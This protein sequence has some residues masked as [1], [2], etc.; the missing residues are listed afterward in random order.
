MHIVLRTAVSVTLERQVQ[1]LYDSL[2]LDNGSPFKCTNT[3][4]HLVHASTHTTVCLQQQS[5][6]LPWPTNVACLARTAN[7]EQ[8]YTEPHA[9]G[10][11]S[12]LAQ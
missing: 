10:S 12:A 9:Q 1:L 2:G 3:H 5:G 4:Y 8:A 7:S 11:K 6:A